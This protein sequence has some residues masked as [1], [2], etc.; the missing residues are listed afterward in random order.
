MPD[1][2]RSIAGGDL[3]FFDVEALSDWVQGQRWYASTCARVALP[4]ANVR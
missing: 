4:I 2:A 1:L 3:S